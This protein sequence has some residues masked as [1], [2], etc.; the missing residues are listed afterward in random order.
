MVPHRLAIALVLVAATPAQAEDT[1][2]RAP[3]SSWTLDYDADSCALRRMFGTGD[4]QAYLE[5]RRFGPGT[6]LQATVASNQ[7][8]P[9]Q[10]AGLR[11]RFGRADEWRETDK[12]ITFTM[13]NGFRGVIFSAYLL[14]LPDDDASG[15]SVERAL[16]LQSAQFNADEIAAAAEVETLTLGRGFNR[17]VT[18]RLGSMAAPIAALNE[19]VEELLTHWDI[20]VAAHKTLARPAVPTNFPQVPRMM[21]YPPKMLQQRMPGLVNVRLAIDPAGLITDCRIQM[22]LS[23]PAFEKS[24][25]ADIQH[26]LEFDPALD[27]DGKPIASYWI[28]RV[29]F[30]IF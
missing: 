21:D 26:A 20:D 5:L 13:D 29:Q 4:D 9:L 16:Y 8:R 28:T 19:C 3:S 6:A 30:R 25:C 12:P 27:K 24:S 2:V 11:Y 18:L 7:L 10:S 15:T 17:E 23:D 1:Q 22:P 14:E